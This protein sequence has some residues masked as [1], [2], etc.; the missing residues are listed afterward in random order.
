MHI[1]NFIYKYTFTSSILLIILGF[2]L[3][4][5]L[6]SL[7]GLILGLLM[8]FDL[9]N[10]IDFSI[11]GSVLEI[12]NGILFAVL[13]CIFFRKEFRLKLLPAG[14]ADSKFFLHYFISTV[15]VFIP[16]IFSFLYYGFHSTWYAFLTGLAAGI[17]EEVICRLIP[18][19]VLMAGEKTREKKNLIV[20][21]TAFTFAVMHGFNALAGADIKYT[22]VQIIFA[23]GFGVLFGAIY[24]VSGNI[25]FPILLH[26][27]YDYVALAISGGTGLVTSEDVGEL[28]LP[29]FII[30]IVIAGIYILLSR[31]FMERW[32]LAATNGMWN[33]IWVKPIYVKDTESVPAPVYD[34][35]STSQPGSDSMSV[36]EIQPGS[37]IQAVFENPLDSDSEITEPS[38]NS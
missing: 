9:F 14:F 33:E 6:S 2:G 25:L 10:S 22:I 37:E 23:F 20:F 4:L 31:M 16:L 24:I 7:A 1:K 21:V 17:A 18:V 29:M 27:A 30:E 36:P 3:L 8:A 26:F 35:V 32:N 11:A 5:G 28:T 15:V 12:F 38:E 19:S 13:F 34:F